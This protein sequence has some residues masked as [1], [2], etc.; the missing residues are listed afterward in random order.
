M[1]TKE[2]AKELRQLIGAHV[3][4]QN[5][6]ALLAKGVC[7]SSLIEANAVYVATAGSINLLEFIASITEAS[8][9]A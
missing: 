4:A 1:I 8:Q 2:Q 6:L 7:L 3:A 5:T 9:D